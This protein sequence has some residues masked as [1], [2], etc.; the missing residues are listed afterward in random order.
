SYALFQVPLSR[1][2]HPEMWTLFLF[3]LIGTT[4]AHAALPPLVY[5]VNC[6]GDDHVDSLGIRFGK[7]PSIEGEASPWGMRYSFPQAYAE[8]HLL[9]QVERFSKESSFSY[10]VDLPVTNAEY[11]LDFRFSEVFFE[12]A[13]AKVF[14][15]LLNGQP[16]IANLD[17]WE[18]AGGRGK[19]YDTL[20]SFKI[21]DGNLV[22]SNVLL[23]FD[24]TLEIT[25]SKG[26]ADNPKCNAFAIFRAPASAVPRPPRLALPPPHKL[27]P[28]EKVMRH[29]EDEHDEED[30]GA[31]ESSQKYGS[32]PRVED[33]YAHQDPMDNLWLLGLIPCLV[34]VV[35]GL[36][37]IR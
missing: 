37:R 31:E 9:Y 10:T 32:G 36:Y 30:D 5:S 17:V 7:D 29:S 2:R 27:Q 3:I 4:C 14:N 18:K 19:P 11:T 8:D 23:D 21:Q 20:E 26:P 22:F 1:P 25:F 6:G 34:P 13:G 24:G 35:Y 33:P 16:L 12:R 15:V 28:A